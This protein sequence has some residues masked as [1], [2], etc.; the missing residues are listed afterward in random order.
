MDYQLTIGIPTF[1]RAACLER[2]IE[3][4]LA[5]KGVSV[6]II[7]SDNA[8][9][10]NTGDI[11]KKYIDLEN[12]TYLKNKLNLGPAAN[13]NQCL[14]FATGKYFMLLGD[15]DWLSDNYGS[16]LVHQLENVPGI[17]LGKCIALTQEG[18]IK[19]ESCKDEYRIE[20]LDLFNRIISRDVL[21]ERHAWF[22]LA[23]E[24]SAMRAAGGFVNTEA[25]AFSDNL[26][27]FK[28]ALSLP[29]I[30]RPEAVNFYSVYAESYGNSNVPS[31]AISAI[32]SV[33]F[34]EREITPTL[35][36][37]YGLRAE[38]KLRAQLISSVSLVYLGR[39]F[40]YGG[41][42]ANKIILIGQFSH[43]RWLIRAILSKAAWGVIVRQ[44]LGRKK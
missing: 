17:F 42:L 1:N 26:L 44:V 2:A 10:D 22:M 24:T 28:L 32:Q 4:A 31:I 25:A 12:V 13:Y 30:Y 27:L 5:Q 41:G 14:N 6:E 35:I 11:V 16:V 8:S 3:S 34:W 19:H 29:I 40:R 39:V 23:A 38:S 21:I 15:D 18:T 43:W 33:L 36:E 20:G 37:K 7:I 9:T